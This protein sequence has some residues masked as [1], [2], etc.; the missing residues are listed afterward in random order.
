MTKALLVAAGFFGD[1]LFISS[2]ADKLIEEKQFD[3][4]DFLTGFPQVYPLLNENPNIQTV[5][6]TEAKTQHPALLLPQYNLS[7][8]NKVF[9]YPPF[10]FRI[11]PP[12]EAQQASGIRNPSTEFQVYTVPEHDKWAKGYVESL[13]EENSRPVIAWMANWRQ[14]A[15]S[16]TE[17]QYWYADD[18]PLTGYGKENRNI[19]SIISAL[20]EKYTMVVV[21]LPEQVTQFDDSTEHTPFARDASLLKYCDYFIGTEG[22][23]ANLASGVGCRTILTYEFPWQ[24]YGPRGTV[25]PFKAG[26][27]IGPVYYFKSGHVYAPL[28]LNDDELTQYIMDMVSPKE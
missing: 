16:F 26:P 19:A 15:F 22:G 21:G 9:T 11:P 25:R 4:V 20:S 13:R 8:Y 28:Y 7:M 12:Q 10:T 1:N 5:F 23:L 6:V 18:H 27:K 2:V 14:K 24:C 3:S 17:E